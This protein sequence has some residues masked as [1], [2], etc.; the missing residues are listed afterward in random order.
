MSTKKV[1]TETETAQE[2]AVAMPPEPPTATTPL[3]RTRKKRSDAGI[4][5]EGFMVL[6]T[7]GS[8]HDVLKDGEG[9]GSDNDLALPFKVFPSIESL[10]DWMATNAKLG[11]TYQPVVPLGHALA[12]KQAVMAV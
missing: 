12:L 1:L 3:A 10:K 2:P 7:Y 6:V 8:S 5:K 11:E 4:P 9:D